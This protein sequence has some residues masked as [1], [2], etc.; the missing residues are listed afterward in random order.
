MQHLIRVAGLE[1]KSEAVKP[2]TG[3]RVC[4][5][6]QMKD[7]GLLVCI[8]P[9]IHRLCQG[10][11]ARGLTILIISLVAP[12]VSSC[13]ASCKLTQLLWLCRTAALVISE[14]SEN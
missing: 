12:V 1:S 4:T 7:T 5:P 6:P 9:V 14:H 3:L 13:S 10:E 11:A 8:T 2:G